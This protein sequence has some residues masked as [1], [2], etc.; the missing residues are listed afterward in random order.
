MN[1][2]G[3][4][5]LFSVLLII[6]SCSQNEVGRMK[7]STKSVKSADFINEGL[8]YQD[9][10]AFTLARE[11]FQN[12]ID[13]DLEFAFAYYCLAWVTPNRIERN[14]ILEQGE[15]YLGN[16]NRSEEEM[17]DQMAQAMAGKEIKWQEWLEKFSPMHPNET[18]YINLQGNIAYNAGD[19]EKAEKY[20]LKSLAIQENAAALNSLAYLYTEQ[21]NL[22]KA[23]DVLDRQLKVAPDLANPYDSM[24]D[25]YLEEK[26]NQEAKRYFEKALEIDPEYL[27]SSRKIWRIEMD[28]NGNKVES[29]TWSSDSS[30]AI[31][32]FRT[33][34]WQF[35]NIHWQMA[36]EKFEE[37]IAVDPQFAMPYLYLVLTPG[38]SVRSEEAR[39]TLAAI[40][41]NASQF[42][43]DFIDFNL[44][45]RDNRKA[46]VDG[47]I[48]DLKTKYPTKHLVMLLDG[49]N[50]FRKKEFKEASAIYTQIWERFNFAPT[51]NMIGYA[52]MQADNMAA[53]KNAFAE[54]ITNNGGHP[55]PYDSMGEYLENM[56]EYDGAYDYYMMA[57]TLDSTFSVSKVR[58]D[59]VRIK[60]QA[61]NS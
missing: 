28:E 54:Y 35:Y 37:A 15:K 29:Y 1:R 9:N 31:T 55:N 58:A 21:E 18:R 40:S 11:S 30:N 45:W 61:D 57:F 8:R 20:Y 25:Y 32:A 41:G 19:Q 51:L 56:K 24:G 2:Y 42:E 39:T 36:R 23:K 34:L 10:F 14:K 4:S 22:E 7:Y 52:N 5:L 48:N 60:Q 59:S 3:I 46:D 33:G 47:K 44:Y 26:N 13:A 53:A 27:T 49:L 50:K 16:A 17:L 38:D 43:Q 12:A 6:I